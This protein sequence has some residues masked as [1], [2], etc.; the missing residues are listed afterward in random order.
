MK[1]LLFNS[2]RS[3]LT[4]VL[5]FAACSMVMAKAIIPFGILEQKPWE[6]KFYYATIASGDTPAEDWYTADFNDFE[7]GTITGPIVSGGLSYYNTTWDL[8]NTTYWVRSH[9]TMT[10]ED[11]TKFLSFYIANDYTCQ[12]YINGVQIYNV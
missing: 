8:A 12:A 10:E 4:L 6:G 5:M 2:R 9:F 3:L 11:L 1:S 7:W